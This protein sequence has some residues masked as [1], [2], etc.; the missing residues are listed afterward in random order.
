M[1]AADR[2]RQAPSL[3]L[4]VLRDG[5]VVAM[6]VLVIVA[7]A[8]LPL[9]T[10]WVMHTALDV[11]DSAAWLGMD[12]SSVHA[13]SD[14]TV[15]ELLFGPGTWVAPGPDG[16]G[17]FYD[18]TEIQHLRDVRQLLWWT[19]VIGGLALLAVLVLLERSADS[20]Q[21]MAAIGLGGALVAVTVVIV[22]IVGA[23]AFDPLFELF[24][25]VFFPQGDWAFD[26]GSQRLVQLY[27]F[28]FW[29]IMAAAL[30]LLMILLG[31][32]AWLAARW[33]LSR[34]RRPAW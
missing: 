33:S 23:I 8:L 2:P 31:V 27:P 24:H 9:L 1:T 18:A 5:F 17:S 15:D 6:T 4:R 10:P 14:W 13:A 29:Q 12:P 26:P 25:R 22:A 16:T 32:G 28:R 20:D 21:V 11:A 19:F 30:G 34:D 3:A 7:V